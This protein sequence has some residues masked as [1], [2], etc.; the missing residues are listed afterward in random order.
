MHRASGDPLTVSNPEQPPSQAPADGP[1]TSRRRVVL[2]EKPSVARD[3]AK[4]LGANRRGNGWLEGN[5]WTVT[6]AIGHL[7]ELQEP[8][9][10]DPEWKAWRLSTLPL[11]PEKFGLRPRGDK[12]AQAQLATVKRLF[13]EAD[14]LVCATDAGR[15]GE[16]IFRY[17][18]T[19]SGCEGKPT[20]RLWVSSLTTEALAK[21]F[22]ALAPGSDYDRLYQA[23]RCRSEADWLVGINA[24]RFFTIEY[25]RRQLLLSLGRVQTPIL[26]MIVGRD[27]DVE[28]FKAEDFWEVHTVCRG[29]TFKHT[30]GKLTDKAE[31]EAIVA[32]VTGQPLVVT[33]V[34]KKNTTANPPQLFDLT[35]LQREMNKKHGFTADQTLKLAQ[36]LYERKHLTYPRTDSCYLSGD[37]MK[38]VP[39]LLEKLRPLKPA[40]IGRLQLDA[41]PVSKRVVDDK[42]V[43]DHH[44][45]IPTNVPPGRL[46]GDELTVYDAVLTRL[47]AAFYPPCIKAVTT[48][49]AVSAAEPFR[50]RGTVLVDPGW[51]V[52]YGNA[53]DD[54]AAASAP[55]KTR[56]RRGKDQAADGGDDADKD[57]ESTQVL[58]DFAEG[59]SN[60]HAPALPQFKT[61]APKRFTEASLLQLMETA[62]KIVTD[63]TL[64]EALKE[65]GVGTPATRAAIIEVLIARGYVERRRKTL[66]STPGGRALI[67]LVQNEKLKSP[68]LTGDW[69]YRLKLVE[70][71]E[72]APEVFM[73]E[74]RAYTREILQGTAAQ[75]IDLAKL[76]PCPRCGAP[77]MRGRTGYGCSRWRDGCGFVVPGTLWGLTLTPVLLRE[78]LV[79]GKS[80]TPHSIVVDGQRTLAHLRFDPQGQPA[81]EDV[82]LPEGEHHAASLGTCPSCGGDVVEGA[83]GYGCTNWKRGCRFIVWKTIAKR[84]ITP[85]IVQALLRGE[86]V[87]PLE[88]FV[89]RA[90]RAF[91]AKLRIAEGAVKLEW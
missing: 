67:A 32:K 61:S 31:A 13:E 58:P 59:E 8:E 42:K 24:T 83:R 38:G 19:W 5:G 68:E 20:R 51:Q 14:E 57:E 12:G 88:G 44:A 86:S 65:K 81:H 89:S 53:G 6:W 25:G 74:V 33:A 30:K 76:G 90:G 4:H 34:A 69:E 82:A 63:E 85:D 17:I 50:A 54:D 27:L 64:K 80:L 23:A 29:A 45:I 7:V 1:A 39:A 70:R 84:P 15:E 75:T 60:P 28:T 55:K 71:G 22:A 35:S 77:V 11:F 41:L 16:L 87:G 3:L 18:L 9:D 26:A 72:Y 73:E 91:A 49:D 52:L 2:A 78:I 10:Y 48:V 40:E 79:H 47:I 66:V 62:G 21:G 43:G 36:E 56:A 37:V 46:A